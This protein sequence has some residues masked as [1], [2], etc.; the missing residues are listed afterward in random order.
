MQ[1]GRTLAHHGLK[2]AFDAAGTK[3]VEKEEEEH[4]VRVLDPRLGPPPGGAA[5]GLRRAVVVVARPIAFLLRGV[6]V[7]TGHFARQ[8]S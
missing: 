6:L 8:K 4:D 1:D 5:D 7:V 2:E 3:V